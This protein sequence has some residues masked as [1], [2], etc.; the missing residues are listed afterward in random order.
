MDVPFVKGED[1]QLT[2]NSGHGY[3]CPVADNE[4]LKVPD[5]ELGAQLRANFETGK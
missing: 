2:H 5:G 3:L 4:D 1:Y